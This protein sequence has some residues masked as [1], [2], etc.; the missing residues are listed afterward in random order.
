MN[1]DKDS[2]WQDRP[3]GLEWFDAVDLLFCASIAL[4]GACILAYSIF[5]QLRQQ[6]E[7]FKIALLLGSVA[8]VLGA[9]I[10]DFLRKRVGWVTAALLAIWVIFTLSIS[11]GFI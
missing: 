11:V 7:W 5:F 2:L 4:L 3:R 9:V 1:E 8:V 10:R 6:Q